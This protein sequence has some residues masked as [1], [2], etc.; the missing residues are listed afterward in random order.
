MI[1]AKHPIASM[2]VELDDTHCP[3]C[4]AALTATLIKY[5]GVIKATV[6]PLQNSLILEFNPEKI[7]QISLEEIV[8]S[9]VVGNTAHHKEHSDDIAIDPVCGMTVKTDTTELYSDF[10][11]KRYFFCARSCKIAFDEDSVSYIND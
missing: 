3:S 7:S 11:G 5:Q 1:D 4:V 6:K 9:A 10:G 8:Q 2:I